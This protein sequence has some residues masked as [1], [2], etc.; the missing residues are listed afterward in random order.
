MLRG[1]RFW[2]RE[3]SEAIRC[4]K[5]GHERGPIGLDPPCPE[6]GSPRARPAGPV[7]L[8]YTIM[9]GSESPWARA[10]LA[11][12]VIPFIMLFLCCL[13]GLLLESTP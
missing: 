4:W 6:C 12:L 9:P 5:C 2:K 11:L 7:P 3:Q 8:S 13:S 1:M 10:G